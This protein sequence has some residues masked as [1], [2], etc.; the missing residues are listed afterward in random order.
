[1]RWSVGRG[2]PLPLKKVSGEGAVPPPQKFLIFFWFN[3]FQK[4]L[5][6]GQGGASP[7]APP[8]KYATGY[9]GVTSD[10]AGNGDIR[11]F[12]RSLQSVPRSTLVCCH[13]LRERSTSTVCAATCNSSDGRTWTI[14]FSVS[15]SVSLSLCN[16]QN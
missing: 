7:S 15:V 13:Q 1:M 5:R 16:H 9:R 12:A 3:V 6:S 11:N 4:F 8:P 14:R 2:C 10:L